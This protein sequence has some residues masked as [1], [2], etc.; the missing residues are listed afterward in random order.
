MKSYKTRDLFQRDPGRKFSP[1]VIVD[2]HEEQVVGTEIEEYVVT[3]QIRR[4]FDDIIDRFIEARTGRLAGVCA[5]ISGFFGSGKSHFL[6]MLG[7]VLTNRGVKLPS[8]VEVEVADY[9]RRKHGLRGI[10]MISRELKTRALFVNMLTYDRTKD[11]DLS[12]FVYK[13]LLRDLGLSEIFWVAEVELM[14]KSRGLWDEFVQFVEK[15]EGMAW[16]DVRMIESRVR[17]ALVRGLMVVDPKAY[18]EMML[19]DEAVKDAEKEFTINPERLAMRL[20]EEARALD[21]EDGRM[22][23]LLDEVGLYVGTE[24]ERLTELNALA[25]RV[26]K[27][28]RGKVWIFATA[29]EALEQVIPKIEARRAELEWIRDRFRI[30]VSL[31]PENIA[32]VVNE[33]LLQKNKESECFQALRKFYEDHEGSLKMSALIRDPARDPHG[34]FTHLNFDDF[35]QT[36]PLMPYYIPLMI[37]IFGALRA[38]GRVSPEL[39][40]RERAVLGVARAA[41]L[42]LL[43]R[44][45]GALVS[46]DMVYDAI[47]EELKAVQSEYQVLIQNEIAKLGKVEGM[48]VASVA[49]AL[50]LLQQV[51]EWIPCTLVNVAAVL[52]PSLGVDQKEHEGKVRACL[53]TLVNNRWVTAEEGKYRFLSTVERTF[54]Q[55]VNRQRIW[56]RDKGDLAKE[57]ARG[58]LRPL[59]KYNYRKLRTFDV[60]LWIDGEEISKTGHLKLK[61]YTPH[62]VGRYEDPVAELYTKSLAEEDAVF[63]IGSKNERFAQKLERV[64]SVE[65]VLEERERRAPSP[66]ELRELERYRKEVELTRSDELPKMLESFLLAGKVLHR[67]EEKELDGK[68]NLG[69]VFNWYMKELADQLFTEFDHAAVR[70]KDEDITSILTWSGGVL[71]SVYTELGLIE[72]NNIVVSAP[73]ADRILREVKRRNETGTECTGY[74]LG[75]HFGSPPYGWDAKVVRLVLATLFK[76]GSIE[77]ESGGKPYRTADEIGSHDAFVRVLSF[78][79]ARFLLGATVTTA[80]KREASSLISDIFARPGGITLD[81]ISENLTA[82]VRESLEVIQDLRTRRGYHQLPFAGDLDKLESALNRVRKQPSYPLKILSFLEEGTLE[83]IRS[84]MPLLTDLKGFCESGNLSI[85]LTI[86]QFAGVPLDGLVKV[87]P[88][89][90]VVSRKRRVGKRIQSKELLAEWKELYDDFIFLRDKHKNAYTKAHEECQRA[91]ENSIRALK[92]WGTSKGLADTTIESALF[93]L[94]GLLCEGGEGA[95]Y[96]D[97]QFLCTNCSRGLTTLRNHIEMVR[98][99]SDQAKNRLIQKLRDMEKPPFPKTLFKEEK[100]ETPEKLRRVLEEAT[101]FGQFWISKGKRVKVRIEGERLDGQGEEVEA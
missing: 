79:R 19:A 55:D 7:Y 71:P 49:K 11:R 86:R 64:L 2:S 61:I 97:Q 63:W 34:L 100:I 60:N 22:V 12:R 40:G 92:D 9:F 53:E 98:V 70:V 91:T 47:D 10:P 45:V 46:F 65:R 57:I 69:H 33:R 52:Y 84:T 38:R 59:R 28:G 87:D 56:E 8:G 44:D 95:A 15:E 77:V 29:Q 48:D 67:G 78:K 20:A 30:N 75:E 99:R 58:S 76:N 82:G 14:L 18:P 3:D 32:T 39:T 66:Q 42:N 31:T 36:Y 81:E 27:L 25:E 43:E 23:L 1:V 6:K 93:P 85:F 68:Q 89:E 26:E 96:D 17:S 62:W 35:A 94:E 74:A 88:S 4:S 54:E 80:Q 83:P 101:E 41:I 21:P 72:Q 90:E 13:I 37:D 24:T 16:E 51:G 50:F 5:W 73:A